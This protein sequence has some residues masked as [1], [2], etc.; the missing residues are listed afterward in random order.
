MQLY[1]HLPFCSS[2]CRYCDFF[3]TV[4]T[5]DGEIFRYIDAVAEEWALRCGGVA[6]P[7]DTIFIG[8]GTPSVLS[9]AQWEYFGE[10]LL[11]LLP[12]DKETEWTTE[13]NPDTFSDEKAVLLASLGIN[14]ITFGVQTLDNRIRKFARRRGTAAAVETVL[15]SRSLD[16][17]RSVGVDL[18]Y[19][20]PGQTAASFEATLQTV[21][22]ISTVKHLS[23]Y[24]LSVADGTPFGNHRILLPLP[25]DDTLNDMVRILQ[26]TAL[27]SGYE[28]YEVSNFAKAEYRCRH[29]IGYWNH[30]PY[31]GLGASA[32][33]YHNRI[34]SW[35]V[36]DLQGYCSRIEHGELPVEAREHIDTATLA[37]EI[38]FLGLRQTS[39]ID[40]DRFFTMTGIPF[41]Q[42]A[43]RCTLE[44]MIN[45]G[46]IEYLPPNWR[47][48]RKGLLYADYC[49]RELF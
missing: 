39:G 46:L 30:E 36:A 49:A 11:R 15:H 12:V 8:G 6:G 34:R 14:R 21:L 32:H 4:G 7:L 45:E 19:G 44:R 3:S 23:A 35:N 22:M 16:A 31:I 9:V 43:D 5:L 10:R 33:S 37:R 18:I 26:E 27:A 47:P 17:F 29:N 28:Q 40:E 1:V 48:T 24:E 20:L 25:S 38:L 41:T 13:S 42:W 2:R